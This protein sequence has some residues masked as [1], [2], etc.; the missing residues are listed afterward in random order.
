MILLKVSPSNFEILVG[1]LHSL[2][3]HLPIGILLLVALFEFLARKEKYVV[4][5]P[6]IIKIAF[7]GMISSIFSCVAGYLLSKSGSYEKVLLAW[8]KWLGIALA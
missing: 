1:R 5:R 2:V 4:L 8:H 7:L 3:I 6:A